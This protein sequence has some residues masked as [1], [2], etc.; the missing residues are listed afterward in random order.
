MNNFSCL[1]I[2]VLFGAVAYGQQPDTLI[3]YTESDVNSIKNEYNLIL[4]SCINE[5]DRK[6]G[7]IDMFVA[8]DMCNEIDRICDTVSIDIV[9][10]SD[11]VKISVIKEGAKVWLNVINAS[12]LYTSSIDS[13]QY[14]TD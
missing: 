2:C 8:A 11:S 13:L 10:R 9:G 14:G 7:I 5:L 12:H 6:Q 1:L 4:D 3:Y